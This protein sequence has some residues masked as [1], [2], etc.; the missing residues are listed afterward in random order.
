[1]PDADNRDQ[2]RRHHAGLPRVL[3]PVALFE[4]GN[5]ATTPLILRATNLLQN[6]GGQGQARGLTAAT[7]L[8]SLLY[9]GHNAA[10]SL[11]ALGGGRV[12][13]RLG[14]RLCSA[15]VRRCTSPGT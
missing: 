10:A 14:P 13:D 6:G 4:L 5:L 2:R 15:P 3:T 8:A 7:S 9:A 12:A 11:A 1:M